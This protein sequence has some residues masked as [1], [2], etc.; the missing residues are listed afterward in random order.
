MSGPSQPDEFETI[1]RLLAPLADA[2][3]AFG[4]TDDAAAIP[5]RPGYD[6]VV[7]KDTLVQGV[8][9]LPDDPLDL[10]ARKLL[11]VNLSDLAAKGAK[12]YGYFLSCAWPGDVDWEGRALFARGL[13]E[14]QRA[15]GLTLLG[16]DTVSTPG[17]MVLSATLMGWVPTGGMIRRAGASP[18]DLLLVSGPIGD[19]LLGLKAATGELNDPDLAAHYRL[20]KP[21]L[22]VEMTGVMAC[23]DVSD[24][25]LADAGNLAKASGLAVEIDLDAMPL[26][27]GAQV[28]LAG[29][30]DRSA[31]LT[32]LATGGDD[33]QLVAAAR[34]PLPGFTVIGRFGNGQ[35]VRAMI[36][37]REVAVT[38]LGWRHG[39]LP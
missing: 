24:G 17:P 2:P 15:F 28:W 13:A 38:H 20:P 3:E 6:L 8:H 27:P 1:Q 26:S 9:F 31:A 22:D 21:R 4:L 25:L 18:G 33:Y 5:S 23:A 32:A 11:R 34:T 12:P 37:G 30:G 35:G 10:V 19:G 7:T 29:Q 39:K 14:D 16:G 36:E